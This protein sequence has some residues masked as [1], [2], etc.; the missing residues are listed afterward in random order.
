[1]HFIM[2]FFQWYIV[3]EKKNCFTVDFHHDNIQ[4]CKT[5]FLSH[6]LQKNISDEL[7]PCKYFISFPAVSSKVLCL[8]GLCIRPC[9]LQTNQKIK[10]N[11]QKKFFFVYFRLFNE[12]NSV[13][14]MLQIQCN[15]FSSTMGISCLTKESVSESFTNLLLGLCTLMWADNDLT[16]VNV[17]MQCLHLCDSTEL[18]AA[19]INFLDDE[20]VLDSFW[21]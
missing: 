14:Q 7:E 3:T 21:K 12:E 11:R 4:K 13:L 18:V 5:N 16:D 20:T 2:H 9:N 15:F 1:M 17:A 8:I 10:A 19:T 6:R